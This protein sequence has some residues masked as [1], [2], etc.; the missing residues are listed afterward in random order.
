[1]GATAD[2]KKEGAFGKN[3]KTPPSGGGSTGSNT[4]PGSNSGMLGGK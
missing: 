4:P 3:P 1:M 2:Q